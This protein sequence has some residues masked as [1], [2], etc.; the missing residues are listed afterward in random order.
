MFNSVNLTNL[1]QV[2]D[3]NSVNILIMQENIIQLLMKIDVDTC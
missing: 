2:A 1:S 3:L